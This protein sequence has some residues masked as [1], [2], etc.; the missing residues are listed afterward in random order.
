MRG[1]FAAAANLLATQIKSNLWKDLNS[2][3]VPKLSP[4]QD[5]DQSHEWIL[6]FRLAGTFFALYTMVMR[7]PIPKVS[8]HVLLLLFC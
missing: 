1:V 4:L 5:A 3:L 6:E 2:F 7:S 8:P